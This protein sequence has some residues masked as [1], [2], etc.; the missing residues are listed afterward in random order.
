MTYFRSMV[1]RFALTGQPQHVCDAKQ[2]ELIEFGLANV[3]QERDE[4]V[5]S[6][7]EPIVTSAACYNFGLLKYQ[8]F[9]LREQNHSEYPLGN[10]FEAYV[11][12]TLFHENKPLEL[13][14]HAPVNIE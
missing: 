6:I 12:L 4:L 3:E 14:T 13:G 7:R 9:R 11:A 2:L 10:E 8:N 5:V 1:L